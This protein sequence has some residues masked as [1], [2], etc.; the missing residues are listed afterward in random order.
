LYSDGIRASSEHQSLPLGLQPQHN[1]FV[2]LQP[3][4][5]VAFASQSPADASLSVDAF[6]IA[7]T[8]KVKGIAGR[9]QLGYA[10][11]SKAKPIDREWIGLPA[12]V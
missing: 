4:S 10:Y 6:E 1:T 5:P 12:E 11:S 2:I 8:G 9:P 7:R 3:K